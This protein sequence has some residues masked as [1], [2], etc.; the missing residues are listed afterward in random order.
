ME[1]KNI[2]ELRNV[3]LWN[4]GDKKEKNGISLTIV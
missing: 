3:E 1:S 4:M 2:S